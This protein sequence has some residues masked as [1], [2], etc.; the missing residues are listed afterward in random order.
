MVTFYIKRVT[1]TC[2]QWLGICVIPTSIYCSVKV[3]LLE[4]VAFFLEIKT[5]LNGVA[6]LWF[7]YRNAF[8]W[9]HARIH[10]IQPWY[11]NFFSKEYQKEYPGPIQDFLPNIYI[12]IYI[13]F[14]LRLQLFANAL[15]PMFPEGFIFI[16]IVSQKNAEH[17]LFKEKVLL[18]L[19]SD[20]RSRVN[21]KAKIQD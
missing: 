7:V 1:A 21:N 11:L 17:F 19:D 20:S 9:L 6:F 16:H 4:S 8:I 18:F 12:Y 3:L 10:I 15:I 14:A 13:Y 2:Y 5:E